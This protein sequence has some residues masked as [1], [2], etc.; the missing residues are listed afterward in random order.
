MLTVAVARRKWCRLEGQT[1][2]VELV[3]GIAKQVQVV[4]SEFPQ[5]AAA[6]TA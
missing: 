3:E 1:V 4:P 6:R 5:T 2:A